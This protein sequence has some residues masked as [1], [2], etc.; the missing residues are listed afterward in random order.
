VPRSTL[1]YR[2]KLTEDIVW[3]LNIIRDIWLAHPFYGYRKITVI[4]VRD[5]GLT[6]N[7]KKV[8]RLMQQAGIQALYPKPKLSQRNAEH[9]V[10]PYLLK[11]LLIERA[12]R[13]GWL[14]LRILN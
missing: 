13:H 8:L 14:I 3:L 11:G 10:Y 4:L 1:Y 6:I 9:K 5:Y 12:D 7:R 2:P